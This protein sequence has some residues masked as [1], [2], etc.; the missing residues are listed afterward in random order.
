MTWTNADVQTLYFTAVIFLVIALILVNRYI[1]AIERR[2]AVRFIFNPKTIE[3]FET[4]MG[5]N[6]T[7][8]MT[9]Y[10]EEKMG[11]EMQQEE[12]L[13]ISAG[14][15]QNGI[16][17]VTAAVITSMPLFYKDYMSKFYGEERMI[18]AIREKVRYLFV[19]FI[20]NLIKKRAG[21]GA[22]IPSNTDN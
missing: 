15:A 19:K 10:L 18:A 6:I 13:D 16:D 21:G 9:R 12:E 8:Y 3:A 7:M 5:I 22:L 4:W 17:Y 14:F 20:E 11:R 1:I 2:H